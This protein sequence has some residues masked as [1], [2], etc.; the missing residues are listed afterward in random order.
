M[1]SN[2][3]ELGDPLKAKP[4]RR[5]DNETTQ[6]STGSYFKIWPD[7]LVSWGGSG[8]P[9]GPG[10]ALKNVGADGPHI[11]EGFPGAPQP[12]SPPP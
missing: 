12:P 2:E 7:F 10:K 3:R 8:L 1:N 9:R 5:N 11:F 6:R 4:V